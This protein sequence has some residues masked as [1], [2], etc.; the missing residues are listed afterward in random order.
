MMPRQMR[1]KQN[2][3][4]V[5]ELMVALAL[6]MTLGVAVVSVFTNNSYSFSQDENISRMSDEARFAANCMFLQS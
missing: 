5:V 2:G 6:S 1:H 3:F 4:S